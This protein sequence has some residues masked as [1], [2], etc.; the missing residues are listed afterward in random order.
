[1]T[2]D[3]GRYRAMTET[4]RRA[5]HVEGPITDQ[6]APGGAYL[7]AGDEFTANL[8]YRAE[9][10]RTI[11]VPNIW[12]NQPSAWR[13]YAK[14]STD[15]LRACH[16][17]EVHCHAEGLPIRHGIDHFFRLYADTEPSRDPPDGQVHRAMILP[18]YWG[19]AL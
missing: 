11:V 7:I 16:E 1:M 5:L 10:G 12:Y 9:D 3:R 6:W 17:Y 19:E 13:R 8:V 4:E 2:V 15:V 14:W 18:T